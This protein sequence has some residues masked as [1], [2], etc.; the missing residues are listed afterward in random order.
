MIEELA[1]ISR[2]QQTIKMGVRGHAVGGLMAQLKS[3]CWLCCRRKLR[4]INC[5]GAYI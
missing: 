2:Q 4:G 5:A 3:R 1:F